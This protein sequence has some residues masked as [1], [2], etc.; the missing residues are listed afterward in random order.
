MPDI[1]PDRLLRDI[2]RIREEC[3][4]CR[5][6]RRANETALYAKVD[7]LRADMSAGFLEVSKALGALGWKAFGIAV[8]IGLVGMAAV[9]S[10]LFRK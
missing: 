8:S 5:E 1:D 9:L 7:E 2:D 4:H 3:G 6:E 10:Y